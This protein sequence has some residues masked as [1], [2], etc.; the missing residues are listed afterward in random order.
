MYKVHG[1]NTILL[2]FI[3]VVSHLQVCTIDQIKPYAS[4][5]SAYYY[6][7]ISGT[8]QSMLSHAFSWGSAFWYFDGVEYRDLYVHLERVC[9]INIRKI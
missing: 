3:A 9:Q 8:H 2:Q 6:L 1:P 5:D 4:Q 7:H